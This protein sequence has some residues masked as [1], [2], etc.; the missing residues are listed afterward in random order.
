MTATTT[1]LRPNTGAIKKQV[2]TILRSTNP[3]RMGQN[4][5]LDGFTLGPIRTATDRV[6][7]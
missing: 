7:L 4:L 1:G 3:T 2:V 6:A 5:D